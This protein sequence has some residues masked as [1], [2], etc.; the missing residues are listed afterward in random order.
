MI[1]LRYTSHMKIHH[2]M[3]LYDNGDRKHN[4]VAPEDLGI[5]IKYNL[6]MRPGR[7]F[8]LDGICLHA[9]YPGW[10]RCEEVE[11]ELAEN[12]RIMEHCTRPY[13]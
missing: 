3:G 7:A 6:T 9:G 11:K 12:P 5:H 13:Q 8:F 4:G 1:R 2:T 10:E